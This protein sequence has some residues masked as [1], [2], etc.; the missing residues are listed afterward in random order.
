ML[1][2]KRDQGFANIL[3][4]ISPQ[5]HFSDEHLSRPYLQCSFVLCVFFC[6]RSF[7]R[8]NAVFRSYFIVAKW[9][10]CI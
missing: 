4:K 7:S 2:L 3:R 5:K 1:I 10:C 6:H 9:N 8:Q